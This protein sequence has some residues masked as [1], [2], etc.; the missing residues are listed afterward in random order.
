[1]EEFGGEDNVEEE[2]GANFDATAKVSDDVD[3]WAVDPGLLDKG[4]EDVV[5]GIDMSDHVTGDFVE[6]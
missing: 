4:T 3:V 6:S 1:M 5:C 2:V